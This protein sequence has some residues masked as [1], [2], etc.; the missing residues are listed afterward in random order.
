MYSI[1]MFFAYNLHCQVCS[2]VEESLGSD[3]VD[4]ILCVAGGWAG[5]NAASKGVIC[6][7][8]FSPSLPYLTS[9]DLCIAEYIFEI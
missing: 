5:G 9:R 3:K 1:D 8:Q 7:A 2:K 4:A 6:E